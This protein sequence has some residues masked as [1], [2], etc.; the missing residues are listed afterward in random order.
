MYRVIL[1]LAIAAAILAHVDLDTMS[2]F[3]YRIAEFLE[4]TEPEAGSV[5]ANSQQ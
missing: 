2:D 5:I 3:A 1:I 4:G